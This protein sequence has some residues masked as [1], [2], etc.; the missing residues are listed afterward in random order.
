MYIPNGF[1]WWKVKNEEKNISNLWIKAIEAK[2]NEQTPYCIDWSIEDV[3]DWI[4]DLGYP[5]YKVG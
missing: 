2:I 3:A 1:E 5:Q 4:S